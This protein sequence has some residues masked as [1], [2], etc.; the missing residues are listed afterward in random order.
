[1][2]QRDVQHEPGAVS[3]REEE[4]RNFAGQAH[5]SEREDPADGQ[6]EG[7]E[8]SARPGSGRSKDDGAEEPDGADGRQWQPVDCQVEQGVHGG[9]DG[10]E[11]EQHPPLV[12]CEGAEQAPWAAPERQDDCG[13]RDAQPGDAQ[14]ADVREQ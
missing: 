12:D 9:E 6:C 5:G 3:E 14:H 4:P 8:V 2:T 11:R 7:E 13:A 10:A 1:M